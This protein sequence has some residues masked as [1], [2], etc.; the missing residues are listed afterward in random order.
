MINDDDEWIQGDEHI[1]KA[2][3]DH[4]Q[5]IFTGEEKYINEIPMNC[6]P[7]MVSQEH[8]DM[9]KELPT[10][11]ELKKVVYSMNTNSAAGPDGMNGYFFQ[12]CWNII[13]I[14]LLA[15]ILAF[16]SGQMI[17]KY[18]SHA[19]LVLLPKGRSISENIMLAQE[20]IHQIK[21]PTIGSNVVIKL[22]MTK[23]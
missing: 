3:C 16:F 1:A 17:P 22:D 18:F 4:F 9:L 20:I 8:N 21:K 15:V 23:A 19:C 2:A 10:I 12:K 14:D 5:H 7:R 6:T 11:D 13:K